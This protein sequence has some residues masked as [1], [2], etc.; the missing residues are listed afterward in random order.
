MVFF[1]DK[2]EI[3]WSRSHFDLQNKVNIWLRDNVKDIVR[4]EYQSTCE[5]YHTCMVHY[6]QKIEIIENQSDQTNV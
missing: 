1:I 4:I 5:T 6:K 2:I 3:F